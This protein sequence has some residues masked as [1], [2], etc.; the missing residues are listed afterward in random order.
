MRL[1][2]EKKYAIQ[3]MIANDKTVPEIAKVLKIDEKSINKYIETLKN[4]IKKIEDNIDSFGFINKT[5]NGKS[6]VAIMTEAAS[7]KGDAASK[8]SKSSNVR[9]KN[10]IW[11]PK[12]RKVQN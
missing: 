8:R 11:N 2:N 5:D 3:G 1:N 12:E 7:Y 10:T 4:S 6:G 9:T